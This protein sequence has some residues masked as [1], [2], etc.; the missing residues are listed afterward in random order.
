MAND[1]SAFGFRP[2]R[3]QAGGKIRTNE[4]SIATGYSSNIFHGDV[5]EMT[6]TDKNIQVVA[7]GNT[8]NLGVFAGCRYVDSSGNQKFSKHWP[9]S[10]TATNI[11]AYVY[12][13]P[14]IV[15]EC[16][17]DTLAEADIGQLVDLNAGAGS[18]TTG[19]SGF[20]ADVGAGTGTTGKSFRLIELVTKPNNA[21][22][23]YAKALVTFQEHVMMGVVS[24]VG[25]I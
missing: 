21:Y 19:V 15:Y 16:Q 2:V 6:G 22:G 20:Y 13:D 8:D 7:A 10:T 24:G 11:V 5:V 23:A 4:Y 3:H 17:C 25:G 1:N 18:T 14:F 12:D 9:A